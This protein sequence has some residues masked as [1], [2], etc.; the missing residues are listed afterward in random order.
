MRCNFILEN[1]ENAAEA[2]KNVLKDDLLN[3]ETINVEGNYIAGMSLFNTQDY[4]EAIPYLEWTEKNTGQ[5]RGTEAL[6]TLANVY[7]ETGEYDKSEKVH[8]DL[9]KR[10]PAYD[11]WI[12]KS[13]ILQ[14]RVFMA[15]DD[16]F[17]ADK[18]IELVIANYPIKD[19]GIIDEAE[20]VQ[21]E[22]LQLQNMEKT[23]ENNTGRTIDLNGGN[24]E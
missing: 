8:Q 24:D 20:Q 11:Y 17:Q 4:Q 18:T 6:H 21:L 7:Y 10:K 1:Y 5:V 14:S 13:L 22:L 2:A 19:D 9:L 23:F 12:A 16:L 15:K 3:D